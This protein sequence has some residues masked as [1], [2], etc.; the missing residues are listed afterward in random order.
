MAKFSFK[1]ADPVDEVLMHLVGRILLPA[2]QENGKT[3][4][5]VK[6]N[7]GKPTIKTVG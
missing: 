4:T 3:V 7:M 6:V 1:K 5:T 2:Q